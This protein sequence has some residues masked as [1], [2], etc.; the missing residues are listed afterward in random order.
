M[1]EIAPLRFDA[2]RQQLVLAKRV[3]VRLLFTGREAGESGRGSVGRAPGSRQ[4]AVSGELLARLYTTSRGLYA[5]SFEQLFP[6][7]RRGLAA[8]QLRLERQGE[9]V[10]FHLEPASDA[11]G[12]G[13]R[14]YFYADRSAASTDF[15][16][17]MAFELVQRPRRRG[18]AARLGRSRGRFDPLGFDRLCAF[19]D[20]PLLPAG[21][22][23]R[24]GPL[25]VGDARLGGDPGEELLAHGGLRLRGRLQLEVF[26]QGASESGEAVDHHLSVSLNGTPVG[27]A[28]F[29]GKKPYRM[30]LSV[31]ASLLREGANELQLTNVADTGVSSLVF[32]D[33][34]SLSYPQASSLAAGAFE[35][36]WAQSRHGD[37]RRALGHAGAP[38]RD[39]GG[40]RWLTGYEASGGSLRFRAE[41]GHRYLAVS[42]RRSLTPRVAAPSLRRL[43]AT[44]NQAD[45]LLIAPR[46]FL[47][48]AE[49]L[50]E[51]RR[52]QGLTTRAVAFEEI[53]DEFG[54]GQPSA[55]AIQ[56]FLAYAFQSWARPSPRYVL[57]LGDASYDPRN[58]MGTSGPRRCRRCGRRR[59]TCGPSP[60]RCSLRSTATTRCPTSRSG[61]SRPRR[62]RKPQ[63]LVA[64]LLAWED[65]G[66]GLS[67]AAALVADNPDLGGRLR[68]GRA[69]HRAE[70]PR[71]PEPQLL[72][73][74]ELGAE[75]R[76]RDPGRARR[77]LEPAE[78]RRPRRRRG[79]G[80]RERLELLGRAEPAGAVA[81]A[82]ARDDELPQRL[83]R[84]PGLRVA[85]RVAAEGRGPRRDRRL[86]AVRALSLDGPAHQYHRA[87]M[88]E[89]TSGRHERLG[90]AV[91]AAQCC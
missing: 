62:S 37:A 12:P 87:L 23:R 50:L 67:G 21:A 35:G 10:G 73:L 18:D 17:E 80:E 49:P 13:S 71:R 5:V 48:A 34:F 55:E 19:R 31:P 41:A 45:Y 85:H 63:R 43:R 65:S 40:A 46:A 82:A 91:L 79:L 33:R 29:A 30:S 16:A 53:A 11:F 3:R 27:E 4:R 24:P 59:P 26:L 25:A 70:L 20:E 86:L 61:G 68:G 6:G 58:F 51:R 22:A 74:S 75:M 42:Q 44:T 84:G 2:Q 90:D 78:L 38:R 83:L 66:Q 60:T 69:R 81:P 32:L 8:S 76:P 9:A 14:L 56:S 52:D 88:A 1:V 89:L 72:L 28:Q 47:A 54:H 7:S 39:G 64:K 36:T 15:S 77:W 57:L